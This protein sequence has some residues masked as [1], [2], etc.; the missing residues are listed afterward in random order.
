MVLS[1]VQV[2]L[3]IKKDD[4]LYFPRIPG[5]LNARGGLVGGTGPE[6]ACSSPVCLYQ[7]AAMLLLFP[8]VPLL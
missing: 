8:V 7:A 5:V 4:T 6:G 1:E 2:T 3:I